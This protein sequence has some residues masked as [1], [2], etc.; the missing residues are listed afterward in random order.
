MT[1]NETSCSAEGNAEIAKATAATKGKTHS[2]RGPRS[3]KAPVREVG[4]ASS[5]CAVDDAM[6]LDLIAHAQ[7]HINPQNAT[8]G[9]EDEQDYRDH[10]VSGEPGGHDDGEEDD[11]EEHD[12][13]VDDVDEEGEE[14]LDAATRQTLEMEEEEGDDDEDEDDDD[15]DDDGHY[16]DEMGDP[17]GD[18][19]EGAGGVFDNHLLAMAGY[20]SGLAGRFRTLLTSIRNRRDPSSQLVALQEL[21]EVLSISNEDTLAG[22]FPTESFVSELIYLM[23][24]PKPP[25]HNNSI[26]AP[27]EGS[28]TK[29]EK[30]EDE[31][32]AQAAAIAAA[33][34]LEDNG[35]RML[36]ACRCLANLIE[37]MPYA[38]HCVVSLGA[39]SVLN[40]KLK[41]IEFIDLAEQVLQTLEKISGEY[42]SAIVR[43]DGLSAMLQ[44]LDF[45]NIHV[46]RTAMNAASNCC[47]RLS[48]EHF[49]KVKDV[50][51]II[52]NVLSYSD[53]RLVE[54]ACRCIVRLVDS[55]RHQGEL[56][57]QLLTDE[58]V[59]SINAILLPTS[60]ST[61]ANTSS[62][63][64][65]TT[66]NTAMYTDVLKA[67]G[68]AARV[69][70]KTAVTLLENN[71]VETLYHLLTG[72]PAPAEDGSGG[73][74]PAA[75]SSVLEESDTNAGAAV[76]VI[77][78][79]GSE[80]VAGSADVAV[81]QNLAH[82]P[83]E[84]VQEALSLVAEL[85][86]PL[87]RGGVFDPRMY[88]EKAYLKRKAK[89]ARA[90]K[91]AR[92]TGKEK[93][94]DVMMEKT[95]SD[96]SN[97]EGQDGSAENSPVKPEKPKAEREIAKEQAQAK[98][99]DTLKGRQ[100]LV[101]R[102][103][104]L[105]L[106]TLVEVYAASVASHVRS[107]ALFGILKIVSF[108]EA[109]PLMEVL[110]KVAL[111]SFIAAILSSRDHPILVQ[112][113]L[114]LVE[115][116]TLKLP[117]VYSALLRREG[118]MWEIEDIASREP[119]SRAGKEKAKSGASTEAVPVSVA[120]DEEEIAADPLGST[121]LATPS[122]DLSKLLAGAGVQ[123]ISRLAGHLPA[124]GAVGVPAGAGMSSLVL[125]NGQPVTLVE[126]EDSNIWRA[127]ILRD[128]F[129][130]EA[131]KTGSGGAD[132]A[133]RALDE[134]KTLV[135]RLQT[136]TT[137]DET[138]VKETLAQTAVLF[139]KADNPISS[140]ELL[141]SGMVDGLYNFAVGNSVEV[142]RHRRRAL[143]SSALMEHQQHGASATTAASALVRRLQETLSRLESV[144]IMTAINNSAD[145]SRRSPTANVARQ[146]RLKLV[147]DNVEGDVP[148]NCT[149]LIVSIH[150]I[151]SF[152]SLNDYLRPKIAA[153]QAMSSLSG[154]A[155][156]SDTALGSGSSHLS[157][158][159]AAFASSAGF[160]LYPSQRNSLTAGAHNPSSSDSSGGAANVS[161]GKGE[162]SSLKQEKQDI[163]GDAGTQQLAE[164]REKGKRSSEKGERSARRSSRLSA[165]EPN[166][167]KGEEQSESSRQQTEAQGSK[168][169]AVR[170]EDNTDEAM[171]RR[172]VEGLLHGDM[173]GFEHDPGFTDEDEDDYDEEV[174]EEGAMPGM[175]PSAGPPSVDKTI[176]LNV[177]QDGSKVEAK[178]P[179]G[180]RVATPI[181]ELSK[182]AP[183]A[184][185]PSALNP[186]SSSYT[187]S[188]GKT[189]YS[190][191]LQKKPTDW[192]LEFEME[193][194]PIS[195]NSTIYSAIHH[196]ELQRQQ[197]S[198]ESASAAA[199]RYIW[200]N[201]YTV[202]YRKVTGPAPS[203]K[204]AES[205]TDAADISLTDGPTPL[206]ASIESSGPYAQILQLLRVLYDLNCDWRAL[207]NDTSRLADLHVSK[208]L[209]EA[210]FVNNK[211]TAKLN[212]QLEEPMIVA[213]NCMPAW[214]LD[215]PRFFSF[216]FPFEVRY[217][218][219]QSTSFGYHR[220][221]NKWQNQQS[222]N[223]ETSTSSSSSSRHDDSLALL[224]R[225]TRQKVRISRNNILAS[226]FKVFE[227][228]G[229]NTSLLEVEYFDEVGTGL[230]PTLEFYALVSKEFARRDLELWRSDDATGESDYVHS[231]NGLF[232]TPVDPTQM[233]SASRKSKVQSFKVLG[234]FVAKALF[235]SRIVDL[236][237][238]TAFMRAVIHQPI[239]ETLSMLK[240]V[241]GVLAQSLERMGSMSAEDL[242]SLGLD[243]T[244]PGQSDYKLTG[245]E[246]EEVT[247]T[248]SN[249]NLY[250]E[251]VIHH[252]LVAGVKPF[253]DAF[254]Q[255]FNLI[256]PI[257]AMSI[258]TDDELVMLFGNSEEDWSEE[259]LMSGIKPDHGYNA[260]SATFRDVIDIMSHFTT[261]ER[262][263]FLQ[264]LTG[265]PKLPIGGFAGLHPQ[266]TIVKRPPEAN[267]DPD[268][269]LP[270]VMTCVNFCKLPPFSSKAIMKDRLLLAMREGQA[271]FHLS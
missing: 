160:E 59:A 66:V 2:T 19:S 52:K 57:E 262:R 206:P 240:A 70:P 122:S 133:G 131:S 86:P 55:Y 166:S 81:L 177:A 1:P 124:S 227:L 169:R 196:H 241:D 103:T 125:A 138:V 41:E 71:I 255:G 4:A 172:L 174:F 11:D 80:I 77:G 215:L 36:L 8:S 254:R 102:F 72:S 114:Q 250:I 154:A 74:G 17:Y 236:R 158:V 170:G 197:N 10:D 84:Q 249:V 7:P 269:T 258:F 212:R 89:A 146:I 222:R 97:C 147:A 186:T 181:N 113:A 14:D 112:G 213:S 178:T 245:G 94:G 176:N 49:T 180:T 30:D 270:S 117:D 235:D 168:E 28:R 201:T 231:P 261:E 20:M 76:A 161:G 268:K 141:R 150:A 13:D 39:V 3:T 187:P 189:S 162:A 56:L 256:F 140:F 118:V 106:P 136:S 128:Q 171:A 214:S 191:A 247:V 47:R 107:K 267:V 101:K 62:A 185:T 225:L 116:L 123:G 63:A 220:L 50:M 73:K 104:Q 51:P 190:S 199:P 188:P 244:L 221:I 38:A 263:E 6:D 34:G 198:G 230:G 9:D 90:R 60:T 24:G 228:Y 92:Q 32:E 37:A 69:S 61:R 233:D 68:V 252:T 211:L 64:A 100:G 130:P 132:E 109:E 167:S 82:R 53:Q 78:A 143:L 58:L 152:Q 229:T 91:L 217:T 29:R 153:S 111:A 165:K 33:A 151:T 85:L 87:P 251:Q 207:H 139:A 15:E 93:I 23:G 127:R 96:D 159:L 183:A 179:D 83:K 40:S 271:S 264:W 45:F 137:Q 27:G 5:S 163:D 144:E 238:S 22:Y 223:Q 209:S 26:A 119:S 182:S 216:L 54:S 35:E 115:M 108:V 205:S 25:S 253:V 129:S 226:A 21:S 12:D 88:T 126:A 18:S 175:E 134:I 194:V 110:D 155:T 120:V 239:P 142:P 210:T 67:L 98:R 149:N 99:V 156:G 173:E 95:V 43:E 48:V 224:G 234:Q 42:P 31:D 260:D 157:G 46:Q 164:A 218:F 265:S 105:V 16:D 248:K 243:F 208:G 184:H 145:D 259:T 246:G 193:G 203:A 79:N 242:E 219:L 192:H 195:L 266:L 65:N 232:P 204:E 135:D 257:S 237:F 200:S 75:S 148:R 121:P 44:Y 202:K